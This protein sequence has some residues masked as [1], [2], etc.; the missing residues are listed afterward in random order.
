MIKVSRLLE[1]E[2]PDTESAIRQLQQRGVKST[3]NWGRSCQI[4]EKFYV[5]DENASVIRALR[6]QETKE[7][8]PDGNEQV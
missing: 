7:E 2:F 8:V 1:Y 4:T 6:I 5:T 3:V